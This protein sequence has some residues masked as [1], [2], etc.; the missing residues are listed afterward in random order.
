MLLKKGRREQAGIMKRGRGRKLGDGR[1]T[2]YTKEI[3]IWWRESELNNMM[4]RVDSYS[5]VFPLLC[6]VVAFLSVWFYILSPF[7]FSSQLVF[8]AA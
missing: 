4:S 1:H 2:E 5:S 3:S 7:F 8:R 6:K